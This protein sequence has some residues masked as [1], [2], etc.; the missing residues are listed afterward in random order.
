MFATEHTIINRRSG[1]DTNH[2][3]A[4]EERPK[5]NPERN[6]Y[7]GDLHVHTKYSFDA[8][9]FGTL[10]T[11]YDAYRFAKGEA[12]KHPAGFDMQLRQP[13]DFYG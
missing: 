3:G 1:A 11:P 13:L 6:A 7:F 10:A 12:I 8:Y 4:N 2:D 5:A 9:A